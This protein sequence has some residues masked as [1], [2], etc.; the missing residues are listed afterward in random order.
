MAKEFYNWE[1]I[2]DGK[3]VDRNT[4][5]KAYRFWEKYSLQGNE[6]RCPLCGCNLWENGK[7]VCATCDT[8]YDL[9][10][11]CY[12]SVERDD[13]ICKNCCKHCQEEKAYDDAVNAKIDEMRGK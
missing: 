9:E 8:V 1:I 3:M 4:V 13:F 12:E 6:T 11:F 2:I 5:V 7:A 10:D